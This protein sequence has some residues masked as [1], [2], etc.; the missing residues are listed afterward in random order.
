MK[1]S[2]PCRKK[3]N[4]LPPE[5]VTSFMNGPLLVFGQPT[6][7]PILGKALILGDN[8]IRFLDIW[9]PVCIKW[10]NFSKRTKC[11][12]H[13]CLMSENDSVLKSFEGNN[14]A[15]RA[16]IYYHP[17]AL[18]F[19]VLSPLVD[20]QCVRRSAHTHSLSET[21]FVCAYVCLRER[22]AQTCEKC[23]LSKIVSS[24]FLAG[25][26]RKAWCKVKFPLCLC[27]FLKCAL[28]FKGSFWVQWKV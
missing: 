24:H 9:M 5:C 26:T 13:W 10:P 21:Q 8:N 6:I 3:L 18:S 28:C 2:T 16:K 15:S 23:S 4:P 20:V 14:R 7:F 12:A 11:S 27:F 19:S 1:L 22:D 25:E 17:Q